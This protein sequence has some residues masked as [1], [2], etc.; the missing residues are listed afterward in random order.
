LLKTIT[1]FI[2]IIMLSLKQ[3]LKLEMTLHRKG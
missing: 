3:N 2:F 1:G